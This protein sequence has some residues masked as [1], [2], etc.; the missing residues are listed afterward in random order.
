TTPCAALDMVGNVWEWGRDYW[1]EN[2]YQERAAS[3]VIDPINAEISGARVV[4]GA[5]WDTNR[6]SARCA[7]RYRFEPDYF[8]YIIGFRL[9]R[10]PDFLPRK[11]G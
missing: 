9:V 6:S 11:T 10:S 4:R 1:S 3:E 5:S 8:N 2:I 7:C